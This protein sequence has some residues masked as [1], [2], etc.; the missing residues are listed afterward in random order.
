MSAISIANAPHYHWGSVCDGWRLLDMPDMSVIQERVPPGAAEVWH[1]H[2]TARQFFYILSGSASIELEDGCV[3][4]EA[5]QGLHV[6]PR[7][8]HR[9][10][11]GSQYEVVF[12]VMSSPTTT[13]DRING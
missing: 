8:R 3:T 13:G 9:F 7:T 12:L 5:G 4:L 10:V 2:E 11:N 6:A 1:M